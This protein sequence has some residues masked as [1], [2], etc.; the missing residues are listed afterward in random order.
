VFVSSAWLLVE[1]VGA[2]ALGGGAL[3]TIPQC[4]WAAIR[5]KDSYMRAQFHRPKSRVGPM[6]AIIAV[7]LRRSPLPFTCCSPNL[8][9]RLEDLGL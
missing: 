5:T 2:R 4:A 6:K 3:G 7:A 1:H 8:V 9:R